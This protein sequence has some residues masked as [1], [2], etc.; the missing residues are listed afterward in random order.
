[1]ITV[2]W[3]SVIQN[4]KANLVRMVVE[5]SLIDRLLRFIA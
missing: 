2:L 4:K 5:S 1:M 3:S